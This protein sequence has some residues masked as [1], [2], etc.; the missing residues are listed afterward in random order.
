MP[1]LPIISPHK[2]AKALEK[3]G[4]ELERIKGSH[5][6]YYNSKTGKI[7]VIPFHNKDLR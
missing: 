5:H 7:A 4:F 2:L 6:Y 1:K 3:A